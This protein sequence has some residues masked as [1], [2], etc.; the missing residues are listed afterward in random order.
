MALA[1]SRVNH[2]SRA[3]V[4]V[5]VVAFHYGS[6][7][8]EIGSDISDESGDIRRPAISETILLETAREAFEMK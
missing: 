1:K 2:Y 3:E 8:F 5:S 4:L 7:P 6:K